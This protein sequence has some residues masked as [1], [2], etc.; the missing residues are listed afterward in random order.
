MKRITRHFMAML[1]SLVMV[2]TMGLTAFAEGEPTYTLTLTG[3]TT[4]HTYEAYQ[5][6][7]G[8]LSTN[9][10]GKKVLSNVQ[11]GTGVTYTGTESAADAAKAL[12]DETM[13]LAQLEDKLTLNKPAKT[14]DSSKDSTVIDGLAAGYYLVK[15]KDGTQANKSDAY[16]KFIVQVVGDA[17]VKVKSDVPTVVKKVKD[18]NDSTGA[19]SDWQDS[20]DAD[21]DD[22]VQYQI[23]GSMPENIADYTT[24]KYVFTDTMSKGLTYTAKSATIKI[25][26]TNV[27]GSFE[28][29]VTT[30]E[31]GTTVTWT[32]DNLKGIK[33]VTVNKETKVVVT[34]SAKLNE[35]A[36]IGSAGN[37]NTVNLTYSNNPNKGGEGETGKT[38][39]DTNIVFTYKV[40]VNKVDQDKISPLKGAGF[41]L[42]KKVKKTDGE[43]EYR[44]V[45]SFTAGDDTTFTFSGLDD[46]DYKLIESTTPAGYNTIDPI[47]FKIS[48]DHDV[49]SDD[50]KLNSLSGTTTIKEVTFT[51]DT[52]EGSLTTNVVNK[53]GSILPSTGGRGTTMIYIIGAALVV[54]AGVVLV[55]RKKMNSDK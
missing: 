5:I 17:E 38:P 18:T 20:A 22:D 43:T 49:E 16:T 21:I 13:T 26:E 54:T 6:F 19:T 53:K 1:L 29:T 46:G 25:G 34:Y 41:T 39:D 30:N 32:C 47:E 44:D 27:T 4:G 11:W 24:Y 50:P 7:T 28:E 45:K 9:E 10:G 48:A 2:M 36:V 8:D 15:D 31:D 42:Q 23:T 33:D 3:T 40:V 12:G 35:N 37:P 55:M 14:V 52:N 51:P